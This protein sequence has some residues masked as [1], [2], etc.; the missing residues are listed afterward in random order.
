MNLLETVLSSGGNQVVN[1][2]ASQFGIS[3]DQAVSAASALLP[4][5]AGGLKEKLEAGDTRISDLLTQ[6]TLSAYADNPSS[7]SS[8]GATQQGKT[9]LTSIFSSGAATSLISTVAEKSGISEG[10]I[11]NMLPVVATFLAGCISKNVASG[12]NLNDVVGQFA[13]AGQGG[14]LGAFK[15]LTAKILG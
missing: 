6:G 8:T 5:V 13:A 14:V 15:N 7:L 12:G 2:L 10:I 9:L 3:S 11:K 4:A 1:N